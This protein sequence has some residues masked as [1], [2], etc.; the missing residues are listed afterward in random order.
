MNWMIRPRL[1]TFTNLPGAG[2]HCLSQVGLVQGIV[3]V[4]VLIIELP[5]FISFVWHL[6]FNW[7]PSFL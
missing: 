3:G 6:A 7:V 5:L 4:L 1:Q 2:I